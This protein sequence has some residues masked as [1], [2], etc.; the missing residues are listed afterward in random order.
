MK[1]S[2]VILWLLYFSFVFWFFWY[3]IRQGATKLPALLSQKLVLVSV[4][5][6]LM[7]NCL[8]YFLTRVVIIA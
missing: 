3:V 8:N 2:P 7:T 4:C 1:G 6:S 5:W